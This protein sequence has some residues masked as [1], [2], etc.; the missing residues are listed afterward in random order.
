MVARIPPDADWAAIDGA[1]SGLIPQ[2]GHEQASSIADRIIHWTAELQRAGGQPVFDQGRVVGTHR[3]SASMALALPTISVEA[4]NEA[5]TIVVDL[6]ADLL[7]GVRPASR[8]I[9]TM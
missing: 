1:L 6:I 8:V 7:D 9:E 4:A 5:L 2:T 3:E